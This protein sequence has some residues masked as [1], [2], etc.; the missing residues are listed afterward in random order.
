MPSENVTHFT[1]V[2]Q[3]AAPGFFL[4]YLDEVNKQPEVIAWKPLIL[5]GLRLQPGMRVLDVGCGLGADAFELAPLVGP[6]GLVTGVDFSQSLISEAVRRG[7]DRGLHVK[8]EVGDAQALRFSDNS[9]DAVRTERMLMH[10]LDG[11]R[12]LAEMARVLR[13]GGRMVVLDVDWESQFCDSPFKDTTRKIALSF[14]DGI[15][16]G[17]IGRSLPRLFREVGM[18]EISASFRTVTPSYD[19]LQLM[20]GGHVARAVAASILS[21]QEADLWWN[22]LAQANAEGIFLY[23]FTA[24]IVAGVK[25]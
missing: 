6:D 9:F 18:T 3:S 17:W 21:E 12:A 23:G 11:S 4:H 22:H 25:V 19:M 14:C 5:D 13:P 2:D 24:F 7:A 8:F 1:S 15:K 10:V 16:N 20:L